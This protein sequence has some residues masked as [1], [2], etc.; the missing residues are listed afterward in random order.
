MARSKQK[1]GK[2]SVVDKITESNYAQIYTV[3]DAQGNNFI[4]KLAK[5]GESRDNEL[6]AR[7]YSILSQINHPNIVRVYDYDKHDGSAYFTLEYVPGKPVNEYFEGFSEDFAIVILQIL[8]AIGAF[9]NM[10]FV[11]CDLKPDNILFD[12]SQRQAK[13]ID[14]GFAA[15]PDQQMLAA[16]T[17]GY[18][19]PE[20]VKGTAI[21]QRSDLYSLGVIIYEILSGKKFKR[22]FAP[23]KGIPDEINKLLSRLVSEEAALRPTIP[24]LYQTFTKYAP[25]Q[26]AEIPAYQVRLPG[27]AYIEPSDLIARVCKA[28]GEATIVISET[29]LGKTR[30]MQELKFHCLTKG[31][32]VIYHSAK[33]RTNILDALRKY[34]LMQQSKIAD[35]ED[36]FQIFEEISQCILEFTETKNIAILIDDIDVLS[37]YEL[38]LFRYIGYGIKGSS[39]LLI[40]T[41]T[42]TDAV[43]SLGFKNISLNPLSN[44]DITV[45]LD[46]TFGKIEAGA[47]KTTTGLAQWLLKQSGGNALFIAEI[48]KTLYDKE[49]LYYKNNQ[50]QINM[51]ELDK[52]S[53]PRNLEDLITPRISQLPFS[54]LKLLKILSIANHPLPPAILAFVAERQFDAILERL[55]NSGLVREDT[56]DGQRLISITNRIIAS[57]V[58]K[59]ISNA[60]KANICTDLIASIE[61][62]PHIDIEYAPILVHLNDRLGNTEVAY[63]YAKI[64]AETAEKIYDYN[65][66]AS[67][68]EKLINYTENVDP[69]NYAVLLIKLASMKQIMGNTAAA[70]EHYRRAI[71]ADGVDVKAKAN[72]GLGKIYSTMG[73]YNEAIKH[74]RTA[75]HNT[76]EGSLEYINTANPLGYIYMNTSRLDDALAIFSKSLSLARRIENR[77]MEADTLYYLASVEWHKGDFKQ[78]IEKAENLLRFCQRNKILKHYAYCASLLGSFYQQMKD[79]VMAKKYFKIAIEVFQETKRVGGL[80]GALCNLGLQLT[81]QGELKEALEFFEKSLDIAAKIDNKSI[82]M[83]SFTNIAIINSALGS[84]E[85]AIEHFDKVLQLSGGYVWAIY[86][87]AMIFLKKGKINEA[88]QLLDQHKKNKSEILYKIGLA[89]VEAAQSN[90][91]RTIE[92]L[93]E[94]LVTIS[95]QHPDISIRVE[96]LFKAGILFY[97]TGNTERATKSFAELLEIT[98][99]T[100]PEHNVAQAI[101]AINDFA[102]SQTDSISIAR[103]TSRLKEIGCLYDYAYLKRLQIEARMNRGLK[104]EE[105]KTIVEELSHALE[106]FESLGAELEIAKLQKIQSRL[107]PFVVEDYSRRVISEQYLQ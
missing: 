81:I 9:H 69:A 30:F 78:G 26:K 17:I 2:Y 50:W 102:T 59:K 24:E 28:A 85:N 76:D 51:S 48:L 83:V 90:N 6:I 74:L 4:L 71:A 32:E 55:K 1:I 36:K 21:N 39:A 67:Y 53:I 47:G 7:E 25:S 58:E 89:A 42:T 93:E 86:G 103:Q 46:R 22:S 15:A 14:F 64:S 29:G 57:S 91:S 34:L 44:D 88:R 12:A 56:I 18:M 8:S 45:L 33:E 27:L 3:A 19:A 54:E 43:I 49:L 68:Y 80:A 98:P 16:G 100:S 60:E 37:D 20:V 107:F 5:T 62:T 10:G 96:S 97:E 101:I 73:N 31:L 104:Q 106:V 82:Y 79:A 87:K 84:Y 75:L 23:I 72:V 99:E 41:S 52:T 63:K 70:I 66:A 105:V 13:L 11:H 77:D 61:N 92:L 65:T 40:G 35:A 94:S 38:A 95:K